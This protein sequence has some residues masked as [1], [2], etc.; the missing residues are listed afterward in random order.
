VISS[1]S[2]ERRTDSCTC[3][4]GKKVVGG[5]I[6]HTQVVTTGVVTADRNL[7]YGSN[8]WQVTVRASVAPSLDWKLTA[9]A[10]C[11]SV[12]P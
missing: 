9:Y 5:G 8:G 7:P 11:V 10:I 2:I 12:S 3:P 6:D 4:A 1:G